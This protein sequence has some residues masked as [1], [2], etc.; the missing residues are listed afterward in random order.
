MMTA[1]VA[2]SSGQLCLK[3][4]TLLWLQR[5]RPLDGAEHREARKIYDLSPSVE[6]VTDFQA[7]I[8]C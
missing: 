1:V 4:T 8:S 3:L 7:L 2:S 5:T 6:N